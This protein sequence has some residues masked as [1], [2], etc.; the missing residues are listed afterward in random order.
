MGANVTAEPEVV[1]SLALVDRAREA[2]RQAHTLADIGGVMEVAER[3][4]RYAK[5]AKLGLDAENHAAALRLEA[6]WR[7]GEFIRASGVRAG[8]PQFSKN[9]RIRPLLEDLAVTWR[10]S[11]DWQRIASV[12]EP[13]FQAYIERVKAAQRPLTTSGALQFAKNRERT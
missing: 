10:Q 4:R 1:D 9:G 8:N 11:S 12:P 13:D 2:L 3:A 6:E 7:A 5:A